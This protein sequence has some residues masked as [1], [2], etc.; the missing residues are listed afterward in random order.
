MVV[1][2]LLSNNILNGGAGNDSLIGGLG[3][4]SMSGGDGN[5]IYLVNS[6]LDITTEANA[7]SVTGG[8]DEVRSSVTRALVDNFENLS[9][10]TVS[11]DPL[12]LALNNIN[13]TGNGLANILVGNG[14]NNILNG[15]DGND[16]L[17][18]GAGSDSL[19]GGLGSDSLD[20]GLGND[21]LNGGDGN[22]TYIIDNALDKVIE[23]DGA[24]TDTIN[25][26]VSYSLVDTDIAFGTL[27]SFVENLTLTGIAAINC[28]GNALDNTLTGNG[29][30]NILNGL[31]GDDALN[32]GAG[33]DVLI[34]DLGADALTGGSG[35]DRF[36]FNLIA[37]SAGASIDTIADFSRLQ[38]DKIDLSTID[39][40]TGTPSIND[41]FTFIGN[42]VAFSNVAGQLRF[43]SAT[44]TI[45]G[46]VDGDNAADFQIQ[47]ILT[48]VT[49]LLVTNFIL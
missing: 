1:C 7:D 18:G 35:A 14:G 26:S 30:A 39:A 21:T 5:D 20:G 16:T 32:G 33:N 45:F 37:E 48:G 36:D 23:L 11:I 12:T 24:G 25:S 31:A 41:A 3:N 13:G 8:I 38:L 34:G 6:L 44:S 46:D 17:I 43:D 22:D 15:L 9:L 27:S 28:T 4:D 40:K 42:D 29:A 49:S 47:I 10:L 19:L 2:P